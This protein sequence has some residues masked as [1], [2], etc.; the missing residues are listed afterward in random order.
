MWCEA[1]QQEKVQCEAEK[2]QTGSQETGIAHLSFSQ[3]LLSQAVGQR[4]HKQQMCD[5]H[6]SK[7]VRKENCIECN[8]CECQPL[9]RRRKN[10]CTICGAG[11]SFCCKKDD[12]TWQR[13]KHCKTHKSK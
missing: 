10:Q 4:K 11:S 7:P 13:K 8:P 1:E 6:G 5:L 3:L 12:G 2:V 9:N